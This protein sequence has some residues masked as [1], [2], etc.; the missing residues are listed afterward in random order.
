VL[1]N[2]YETT[3]II[4]PDLDDAQ[5]YAIVER[6]ESVITDN[7]G[8]MLLRDDWG[9]RR[10]AYLIGGHQKGHYVLLNHLAP[11]G[12]IV[13]LERN[14]RIEDSVLRFLTVKLSDH[15]DVAPRLARA[16]EQRKLRSEE[17]ARRKAEAEAAAKAAAEAEAAA[18]AHRADY[19]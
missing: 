6:F 7:E 11:A 17:E 4:R 14:I 10:L 1:H 3:I 12:L 8:H 18:E 5:T 2:E 15:V 16:E 13:E 19:E 9:K